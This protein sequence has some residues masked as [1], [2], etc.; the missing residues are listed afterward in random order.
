MNASGLLKILL[1][2]SL[3]L[4]LLTGR[5]CSYDRSL[6]WLRTAAKSLRSKDLNNCTDGFE[7]ILDTEIMCSW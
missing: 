4:L 7:L 5:R 6:E 2:A 1:P 3:P